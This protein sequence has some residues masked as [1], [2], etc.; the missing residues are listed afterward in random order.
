[1]TNTYEHYIKI[2]YE[3][4]DDDGSHY[5]YFQPLSLYRTGSSNTITFPTGIKIPDKEDIISIHYV[6]GKVIRDVDIV[7]SLYTPYMDKTIVETTLDHAPLDVFIYTN[8]IPRQNNGE[9]Q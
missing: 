3:V 6:E 1:M 2:T 5:M 9:E 4:D 7:D 8:H